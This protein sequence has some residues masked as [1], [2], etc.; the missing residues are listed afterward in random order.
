MATV[1]IILGFVLGLVGL[2]GCVLPFLPGPP[3]NF[4][5]LILLSLAKD[6]EPFGPVFLV[7]M[8]ILTAGVTVLDYMVPAIGA[9]RFGASKAGVWGSV[10]GMIV[11]L[12]LFPP[13][14][15]LL[16][17]FLGALV[18]ELIVGK[19]GKTALR[20]GWGTFVGT[21]IGTGLKLA[22]SGIMFYV[23]VIEMF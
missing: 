1:I 23:Y 4:A 14:G 8:G 16:G 15:M 10:I 17:A 18:G 13:W 5:A 3:L 2:A 9:R 19:Q 20:A 7:S 6:W 11:G 12:V 22:V 21:M